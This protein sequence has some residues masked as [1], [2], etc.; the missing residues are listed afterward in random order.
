MGADPIPVTKESSLNPQRWNLYVYV[1]INPLEVP[2]IQMVQ[3]DR[4]EAETK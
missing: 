1:N 4:V 2:L 3:M